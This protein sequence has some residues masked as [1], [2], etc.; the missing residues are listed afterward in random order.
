MKMYRVVPQT[1]RG[2]YECYLEVN[3]F[4]MI[5]W[6]PVHVYTCVYETKTSYKSNGGLCI[7]G[8]KLFYLAIRV[9]YLVCTMVEISKIKNKKTMLVQNV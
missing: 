8:I 5:F 7:L 6:D 2:N 1:K 4:H 3:V 9:R